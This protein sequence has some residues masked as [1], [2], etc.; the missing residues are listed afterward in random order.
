MYPVCDTIKE[1][2]RRCEM[3][4]EAMIRA[5]IEPELKTEAEDIFHELGLTTTEAITLFYQQVRLNR[6]LPFTVRLPNETTSETFR[7]TDA[8]QDLVECE[9]EEELFARLGI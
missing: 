3:A 8:G 2:A 4:K 5:R 9:D 1:K 6:G 7:K